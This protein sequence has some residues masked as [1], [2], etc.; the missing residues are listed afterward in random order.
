MGEILAF[1]AN[2]LN[3]AIVL[4]FVGYG[5]YRFIAGR[6]DKDSSWYWIGA[7]VGAYVD[8]NAA[9]LCAAD[10]CYVLGQDHQVIIRGASR[11][12][13]EDQHIPVEANL[14]HRHRHFHKDVIHAHIHRHWT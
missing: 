1:G 2:T 8:I 6:A 9:A 10:S 5:V 4:P 11:E 7:A 12:I 14:I 13:L 3:M